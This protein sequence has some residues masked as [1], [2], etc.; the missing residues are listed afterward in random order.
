MNHSLLD[1]PPPAEM[2]DDDPLQQRRTH[3][4]VPNSLGIHHDD[5]SAPAHA[6]A[7]RL[8]ALDARGAEEQSFTLE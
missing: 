8:A 4:P 5:R 3:R 1:N 2:L 7:W 6:K